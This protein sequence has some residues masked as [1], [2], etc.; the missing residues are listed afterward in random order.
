MIEFQGCRNCQLYNPS[1]YCKHD[2]ILRIM[3]QEKAETCPFWVPKEENTDF[4][5]K[6][7]EKRLKN[8]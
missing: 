5:N 1:E 8:G 7:L 6:V 2:N 3:K 4:V